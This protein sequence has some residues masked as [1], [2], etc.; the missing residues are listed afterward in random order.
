MLHRSYRATPHGMKSTSESSVYFHG[1]ID[2]ESKKTGKNVKVQIK[3]LP[4]APDLKLPGYM[5]D[6]AAGMD[7]SAVIPGPVSISP[8]ETVLL[9]TGIAVALPPGFE[10]QIRPRSGLAIKKGLTVV[11]A[12]GT[13]DADYRGEIKVGLI[14]LGPEPVTI[15]PGDRIA[16]MVLSR[17]WRVE[18]EQVDELGHTAR[19][20]GGFG[21]TGT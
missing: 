16:Q 20:D 12:P 10:F 21:H 9:P 18:W 8:G 14:N 17:I 15:S 19:G 11:N 1:N 5:S 4:N 3:R 2:P 7:L 6:L 13:I